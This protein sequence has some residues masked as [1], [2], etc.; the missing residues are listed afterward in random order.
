ML[1]HD[2][3]INDLAFVKIWSEYQL[4]G[5]I[6]PLEMEL[7]MLAL[8]GQ[9][10]AIA[11]WYEFFAPGKCEQLDK[12][13]SNLVLTDFENRLAR[14]YYEKYFGQDKLN[15]GIKLF[16]YIVKSDR[17]FMSTVKSSRMSYRPYF[18]RESDKMDKIKNNTYL[19]YF[20]SACKEAYQNSNSAPSKLKQ[21]FLKTRAQEI[22]F[23]Y[24]FQIPNIGKFG[25]DRTQKFNHLSKEISVSL[26][27]FL[28]L[29][30]KTKS[31]IKSFSQ[32][33]QLYFAIANLISLYLKSTNKPCKRLEKLREKIYSD[34]TNISVQ[35]LD[36]D[37]AKLQ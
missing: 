14:G 33:P 19:S 16:E 20:R 18:E 12:I 27:E 5:D 2:F 10:N 7:K 13:V 11:K 22:L 8:K 17:Y 24:I 35:I 23:E 37:S 34:L 26:K 6:S 3:N 28:I 36:E 21:L 30:N 25:R 4:T 32:H 1:A 31:K 15:D 29:H 9:P